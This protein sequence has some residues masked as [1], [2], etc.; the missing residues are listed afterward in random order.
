MKKTQN[1]LAALCYAMLAPMLGALPTAHAQAP[2]I[3]IIDEDKL[4]TSYTKYRDALVNLDKQAQEMDAKLQARELLDTD[5][6]KRF[7]E[8]VLKESRSA[9]ES[10]ELDAIVKKGN[11]LRAEQLGLIGKVDRSDAD[12]KRL[13]QLNVSSQLSSS[14]IQQL[15]DK[16]FESYKTRQTKIDE[17]NTDKAN[18]VIEQVAADKKLALVW[19]K[20]AVI[21]NAKAIDITDEVLARLNKA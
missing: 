12:N 13:E 9:A 17:E 2:S 5:Q 4:A 10:T 1:V 16:L 14:A 20:R 7:D 19:R 3:G 18:K 8:L 21:W 6:A 15:S 11:G